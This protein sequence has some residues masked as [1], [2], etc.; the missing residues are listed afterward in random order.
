M[1]GNP[2]IFS[3]VAKILG[4]NPN[5]LLLIKERNDDRMSI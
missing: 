2:K 1:R 3:I 5:N 4:K